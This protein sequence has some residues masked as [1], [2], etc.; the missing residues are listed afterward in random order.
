MVER[1]S[2][3]VLTSSHQQ[4]REDWSNPSSSRE[5]SPEAEQV[6]RNSSPLQEN[7]HS[8]DPEFPTDNMHFRHE[9]S[10]VQADNGT[11]RNQLRYAI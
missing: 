8:S 7:G 3:I 1:E 2:Y 5:G 4:S 6:R 9:A 10:M 11:A